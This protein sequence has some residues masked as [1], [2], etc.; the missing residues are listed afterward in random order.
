[1]ACSSGACQSNNC[2]K[3][4]EEEESEQNSIAS[5]LDAKRGTESNDPQQSLCIKCKANSPIS[6]TG[7]DVRFCADC[8]RSNLYGKF[9]LAVSSHAMITP[10]DKVL[11]A[12][13]GGPASRVALQFVH[14]MQNRAQKNFDASR[15]RSLPVF[16]VGVA[17]I[18]ESAIYPIPAHEFDEAITEI[19]LVVSNLAPPTKELHIVPIEN[20]YAS[21]SVDKRNRLKELLDSVTDVTGKEDLLLH[22]KMLSLQ[23]IASENGYSR[24]IL[25][26]CTSRIACHVISAAVKGQGYSL[27]A[28]IQYV[29]ARWDTP[30][31]LPLRDCLSQE[32]NL[33]CRVDGLKTVELLNGPSSG[34]NHLVSSFVALLQ[35]ENPSRECTIVRT[36]GKLTP[37]HFNR[38]P[39]ISDC[40]V[41]LATRRRQKRFSLQPKESISSESFCPIC[42]SPLNK[43]EMQ[44]LSGFGSFQSSDTFSPSCCPS[45]RFQI[46]P[47]DPHSMEHFISL[48]PQ[49]LAAQSK[50]DIGGNLNL[51]REQIQDFLLSDS[52]SET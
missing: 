43:S 12:F 19:K 42:I 25:G 41:P 6:C 15:D 22:L 2:Y 14:E 23:K 30:I 39:E 18:D 51:L 45:C 27:S 38:I 31:V 1:M 28:N 5:I 7:E 21:D 44:T 4:E 13:S 26:S 11:V 24:L 34:I 40:N 36:A 50:H 10:S 46:L 33:L 3:Q 9:R 17:V 35:E 52:D 47:K 49:P 16:G 48:L 37:F 32:L 20:V 29:D 8:F